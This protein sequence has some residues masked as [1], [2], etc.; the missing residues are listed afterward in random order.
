MINHI[1]TI[2]R[3]LAATAVAGL[4]LALAAVGVA[5]TANAAVCAEQ[6]S[7]GT[8]FYYPC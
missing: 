7:N 5:G 3:A 2:V 1:R 4:G 8:W 6:W